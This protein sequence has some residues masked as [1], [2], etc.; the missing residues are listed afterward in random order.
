MGNR[1]IPVFAAAF[2]VCFFEPSFAQKIS[3]F[4]DPS[5][6]QAAARALQESI[7]GRYEFPQVLTNNK[8]LKISDA[9]TKR[10]LNRKPIQTF[11]STARFVG[12]AGRALTDIN[13]IGFT[14]ASL[15]QGRV[16]KSNLTPQVKNVVDVTV[17]FESPSDLYRAVEALLR[18]DKRRFVEM[19]G[20]KDSILRPMADGDRHLEIWLQ[21]NGHVST[22]RFEL[23][24]YL[25]A[26]AS[27][28]NEVALEKRMPV[29]DQALSLTQ[30]KQLQLGP[31]IRQHIGAVKRSLQ[32]ELVQS[33]LAIQKLETATRPLRSPKESLS[34]LLNRNPTNVLCPGWE[35]ITVDH[36][37]PGADKLR[38]FLWGLNQPPC[39][40]DRI[41]SGHLLYKQIYDSYEGFQFSN[42]PEH[43][44]QQLLLRSVYLA[45]AD[46]LRARP[47]AAK[48]QMCAPEEK[49]RIY[50]GIGGMPLVRA[51]LAMTGVHLAPMFGDQLTSGLKT[52][53]LVN[54]TNQP[55]IPNRDLGELGFENQSRMK[56]LTWDYVEGVP[57][58]WKYVLGHQRSSGYPDTDK[59]GIP[60]ETPEPPFPFPPGPVTTFAPVAMSTVIL[61]DPP[62]NPFEEWYE[63]GKTWFK[64]NAQLQRILTQHTHTSTFSPFLSASFSQSMGFGYGPIMIAMDVCPERIL[65]NF[66]LRGIFA[67]EEELYIPFFVLPEEIVRIEGRECWI[68]YAKPDLDLLPPEEKQKYLEATAKFC[69]TNYPSRPTDPTNAATKKWRSFFRNFLTDQEP[70]YRVNLGFHLISSQRTFYKILAE[71]IKS[72]PLNPESEMTLARWREIARNQIKGFQNCE[73]TRFSISNLE[74]RIASYKEEIRVLKE[75][76]RNIPDYRKDPQYGPIEPPWPTTDWRVEEIQWKE[77]ETQ[78]FQNR[79]ALEKTASSGVCGSR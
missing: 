51:P 33:N 2:V 53:G 60:E 3:H 19:V 35:N 6:V 25:L 79:I 10:V 46:Y 59:N 24:S 47:T 62:K 20:F 56:G 5:L 54:V 13:G 68:A 70:D 77:K 26:R 52:L 43:R 16:Q 23:A 69:A 48:N 61:T 41:R 18:A 65:P 1:A 49:I 55:L 12:S 14:I 66:E 39:H 31:Q 29:F 71:G 7:P 63:P 27:L 75:R 11:S 57:H 67:F 9:A 4:V 58:G 21:K 38:T 44:A 73:S 78:D 64:I 50:R 17:S 30:K 45:S 34:H 22:L 36:S 15:Y 76:I 28:K 42:I 40:P 74:G 8:M 37:M 32:K 72:S